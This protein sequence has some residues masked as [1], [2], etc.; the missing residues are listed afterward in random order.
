M[1]I[2]RVFERPVLAQRLCDLGDGRGLL[3]DGDVD[4]L[5]LVLGPPRLALGDDRV[6]R[7]RG[8]AG[9][10]VADDQLTLTPP[11]GGHR[12]DRRDARVQGLLHR[13][14]ADDVG[15]LHLE[16][17]RLGA[18]DRPLAVD[19]PAE[20]VDDPAQEPVA[21]RHRQD[22]AGLLDGVAF[23]DVRGLAQDHATDLIFVEVQREAE[24]AP[25]ELEQLVRHGARQALHAGDPVAGLDDPADL[26]PL[27]ARR[28]AFDVPSERLRDARGIDVQCH[29]LTRSPAVLLRAAAWLGRAESPP[30]RRRPHRRHAPRP[31]RRRRDRPPP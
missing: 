25:G 19:G 11:D 20:R 1:T 2:G 7:D 17:P 4:A 27:D 26:P 30:S 6:D 8:L 15:G 5:D 29:T 9:L 3:A 24:H 22:R 21:H 16:V 18:G 12:V 31:H 10:A 14:A 28:V 23:F 13:L